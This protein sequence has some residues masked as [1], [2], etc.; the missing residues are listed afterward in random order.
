MSSLTGE[1]F[2]IQKFSIHDGPGI[3]TTVFLK[4]C[5]LRCLWCHN[6]ESISSRPDVSFDPRRCIGCG[7]CFKACPAGVHRMEDGK[8]LLARELCRLC[9][10]CAETCYAQALELVGRSMTV[11]EVMRKV[12]QDIPFYRDS[13]GGMTLSGGEPTMQPDFSASLLEAATGKG[14]HTAIETCGYCDWKVLERML[15]SCKLFLY[16]IKAEPDRHK[17]L[18]G[19]PFDRIG[20]NLERL[21]AVGARIWLRLPTIP[22]LNDTEER[23]RHVAGLVKALP[24]IEAVEL[25]SY[26]P[27]G[28]D[29]NARMGLR[30]MLPQDIPTPEQSTVNG[31][32]SCLATMGVTARTPGN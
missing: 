25:V 3:R 19:V 11:E 31:W 1:V 30:N 13:G 15:P 5:P 27:L 4:G 10:E 6:P 2:D 26:H 20:R 16:D 7:A 12:E 14:I 18:T 28:R 32:I 22:G 21:H 29:K 17:E 9:G 23:F 8:H 24:H